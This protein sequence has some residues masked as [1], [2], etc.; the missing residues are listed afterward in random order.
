MIFF[1]EHFIIYG[2]LCKHF[3]PAVTV[4]CEWTAPISPSPTRR[5]SRLGVKLHKAEGSFIFI[6]IF[7]F[8]SR[9]LTMISFCDL[10]HYKKYRIW[11][12]HKDGQISIRL[13]RNTANTLM[14]VRAAVS[15][16][17]NHLPGHEDNE[18][19]ESVNQSRW[20]ART[21]QISVATLQSWFQPFVISSVSISISIAVMFVME[22]KTEGLSDL[23][24]P[25]RTWMKTWCYN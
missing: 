18:L 3:K 21:S 4:S 15:V 14:S 6:F 5:G 19:R 22:Q 2:Q 17:L 16:H 23:L 12:K 9:D 7:T 20:P 24:K 10:K 25:G 13:I 11:E 8:M 1:K